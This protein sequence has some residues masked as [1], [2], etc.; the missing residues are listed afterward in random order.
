MPGTAPAAQ[1]LAG[2]L[3]P[4]PASGRRPRMSVRAGGIVPGWEEP[5]A[6]GAAV[7]SAGTAGGWKMDINREAEG[8]QPE[9]RSGSCLRLPAPTSASVPAQQ[10]CRE[11]P[12]G[13]R[14]SL[15]PRGAGVG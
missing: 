3:S 14:R 8:R 2:G 1:G 12:G 5:A 10:S 15:R 13:G 4:T 9:W 7:N 11:L 6:A